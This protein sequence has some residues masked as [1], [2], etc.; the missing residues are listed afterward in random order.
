MWV[1]GGAN[2]TLGT[3]GDMLEGV[4]VSDVRSSCGL[5]NGGIPI[6]TVWTELGELVGR[7]RIA[8]QQ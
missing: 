2:T 6:R 5:E 1:M 8:A 4:D 7:V 3:E